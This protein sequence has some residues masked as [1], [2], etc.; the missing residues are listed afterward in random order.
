VIRH[1]DEVEPRRRERGHI[2]G[3][4][5]GLTGDGTVQTGVSRVRVDPGK[6]STPAHV[7]GAE[8]EI[9]YVL[10]GSGLAWRDGAVHELGPGDCVV[11]RAG[12]EANTLRAGEEGLDVLIVGMRVY[13]EAAT[14]PRA[15]AGWFGAGWVRLGGEEDHPWT[16]EAAVGPPEVAEPSPRPETIVNVADVEPAERITETIGRRQR[17]LGRAAGS[18]DSGLRVC[19]V[20]PAKLNTAPHCHSAEEEIFVVLEGDGTLLLWGRG[21]GREPTE[22]HEL[23]A[24]HV[25][26]RRAGTGIAHAFR[27]GA[28]G[29]TML[30]YGT[31]DPRDVCYYPRSNKVFLRGV[32]VIARLERVDY[33]DGEA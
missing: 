17:D 30:M 9:V 16:R 31:R 3:E 15:G 22:Q 21:A 19:E 10:G 14:L 27:G 20:L 4:W 26:S 12:E 2:A 33:W 6:W 7:H 1:W 13:D 29:L 11:R 24:G 23:R 32:G 18:H 25:V 8:E 5:Q 28:D